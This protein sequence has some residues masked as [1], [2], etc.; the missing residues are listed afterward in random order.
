MPEQEDHLYVSGNGSLLRAALFNLFDNG[1]KFSTDKKVH[2]VISFKDTGYHI[3]TINDNGPGIPEADIQK[4]FEPFYR[5]PQHSHFK[6]SGV[7][8]SLVKSI[9]Q[10]HK[11][12]LEVFSYA[13]KGTSFILKF[14]IENEVQNE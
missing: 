5:S 14:P 9:L 12:S 8:L 4:I 1:C 11:V 7:G 2:V 6:G 13:D 10:I 3:V